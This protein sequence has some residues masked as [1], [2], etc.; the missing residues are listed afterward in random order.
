MPGGLDGGALCFLCFGW[1]MG[2]LWDPSWRG[3]SRTSSAAWRPAWKGGG[4][5][6]EEWRMRGKPRWESGRKRREKGLLSPRV[7][8]CPFRFCRCPQTTPERLDSA[9]VRRLLFQPKPALNE[10]LGARLGRFRLPAL[11]NRIG[12]PVGSAAGDALSLLLS[13]SQQRTACWLESCSGN[14]FSI[15]MVNCFFDYLSK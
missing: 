5:W 14:I 6:R 9:Q 7:A 12:G 15:V 4:D 3:G 8:P 13:R 11:K 2:R 1:A 10:I